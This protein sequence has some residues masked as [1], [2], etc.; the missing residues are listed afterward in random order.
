MIGSTGVFGQQHAWVLRS[1]GERPAVRFMVG[2]CL[3]EV[4]FYFAYRYGMSFSHATAAPFWFPD[5]LLLCTL[6]VVRPRWWGLLLVATLPIRLLVAV[7]PAAPEWFLI[8]TFAIDCVKAVVAATLLRRLMSD[9]IRFATL[10]DFAL[11]GLVAVLLVPATGA[12]AG[13]AARHA[14][15]HDFW[16]S[17]EQWFYGDALANLVVTPAIFYWV[18]RPV[19]RRDFSGANGLEALLLTCGL[20][21]SASLAFASPSSALGFAD[22]R[23]FAPVPFLFW[24]ALRF[25]MPG[26]S[27]AVALLTCFAVRAALSGHEPFAGTTP[28]DAA[29]ALQQFLLLRAAPLL[30]VAALV[31][32]T[33]RV[34]WSLRESERRFRY[35]ADTAPVLIWISG[36]DG[37]CEYFN[38]GWLQF[39]GRTL[40]Q[41]RG[42]GWATGVHPLDLDHCLAVY[43]TSFDARR[44]FEMDYRLRHHDGEYRWI[45]DKGVPRY[46]A[47]GEF[48]GFIGSAVDVTDRRQQEAA[49]RRSDE[50]YR[51]VVESQ[52]D[53]VCR[54]FP[55][56]S[57]TFANEAYC[58]LFGRKREE[59]LGTSFLA[60]LPESA[61]D[62]TRHRIEL[63][64]SKG[65]PTSWESDIARSDGSHAWQH[66]VCRGIVDAVGNLVEF[67]AIGHDVTDRKHVEEANQKL[68]RTARLAALGELTAMIAHQVSQPLCAILSNAEAAEL[69]VQSTQPPSAEIREILADICK[70][71]LRADQAIRGIRLL[72]QKRG[73]QLESIDLNETIADVLRLAAGD[74]IR[75]RVRIRPELA[76]DVPPVFADR[77]YLEQVLLNL[78]VNGMDAMGETAEPARLLTVQT[79]RD[80]KDSV[81]VAVKD[82]GRGISAEQMPHLFESF[83]T[84]KVDGMGLGLSISRSII[85]AH[86]GRIWAENSKAGGAVLRFTLRAATNG[87]IAVGAPSPEAQM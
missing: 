33:Q 45:L 24:A 11:F 77:S 14:L 83:F 6:L 66:W 60:L 72:T 15:G 59:L 54:F 19:T 51:E 36:S 25:G 13:A 8:T 29:R 18:L 1:L 49:L 85:Q 40:E 55:D 74:A 27:G 84:T 22:S 50:R 17:W 10:R 82:C 61:R 58:R 39:T 56:L 57:L 67:Q 79:I 53:F 42:N 63:A 12:L 70:D 30:L 78:I 9:P 73:M 62:V 80:G 5:S 16:A 7:P 48:L 34:E 69:L 75:R 41:E 87:S 2:F 37:L 64:A 38:Q 43:N 31:E 20:L 21:L 4:A 46:A 81:Q 65:E 71:A 86:Q 76:A 47:S 35:M 3:F 28:V 32:Q 52:T 44:S 23:F 26:A 68:A